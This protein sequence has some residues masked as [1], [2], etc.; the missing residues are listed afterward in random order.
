MISGLDLGEWARGPNVALALCYKNIV[1]HP[2]PGQKEFQVWAV[3]KHIKGP[4]CSRQERWPRDYLG[5]SQRPA[6]LNIQNG[7]GTE[8]KKTGR[9]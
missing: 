6:K 5:V 3:A 1:P 9:F 8:E 2:C 4:V 7:G